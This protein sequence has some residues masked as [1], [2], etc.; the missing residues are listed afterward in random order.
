MSDVLVIGGGGREHALVWKLKQSPHVGKIY[1]APG[2][3][4]T[5]DLAENVGIEASDI[6]K[7]AHFAEEKKVDLTVVGP[8]DPLAIGI[9]DFFQKRGLRIWGPSIAAAR[10]EASKAFAKELMREAEIPTA[11]FAVFT[12]YEPALAHVHERGV[13]IVIKA[14]GLSLGKGVYV[15]ES[16]A[17]AERAL[18][19]LLVQKMHKDAGNEVVI[20]DYI[21]GQEISIHALSDGTTSVMFPPSQDHKTIGEGNTGKNTGGMGSIA[22]VPWVTSAMLADI[23]IRVVQPALSNMAKRGTP[24]VGLLYPGLKMSSK[25][26]KVLE[27]NARFGDP[28]TQV[29]MRLM[30][31]DLFE[32]LDACVEGTLKEHM[33]EW[34][35]GFAVNVVL[36][37]GG[38]P[39]AYQKGIPIR[40]I[41][42]AEK[43]P[44]VVVFHAGTVYEGILKTAG[45]RVLGVSAVGATL[46][47]AID[48]AYQAAELIRFEGKYCRRDI[49]AAALMA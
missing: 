49:G 25:G 18:D 14:S 19:D 15:C 29:Y 39:D 45:G 5:R 47:E 22:P 16:I 42:E 28:E 4:G 7:L 11:S 24:F 17:D 13:P 36:A 30:K 21:D 1:V 37:S 48:R 32:I 43:V 12:E 2:N 33:L 35:G 10:I 41:D 3:G 44:G 20:E 26:P 31:S 9:V 6:E 38:Y 27:F 46:K 34:E 40:G 23:D 8:D